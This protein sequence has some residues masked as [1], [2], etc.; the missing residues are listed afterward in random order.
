MTSQSVPNDV[1]QRRAESTDAAWIS[2][3]T[4]LAAPALSALCRDLETLYRLNPCLVFRSWETTGKDVYHTEFH[5]LSNEQNVAV[6]FT[7]IPGPADGITVT[8]GQGIKKR[9][10]FAIEPYNTGSRLVITDDY[11]KLPPSE[12][13]TRLKE[14]DKSLNAW[15]KSL[16]NYF[17]RYH[18]WSW[19]A[20]WRWYMRRLWIPMTPSARR[21][22]WIITVITLA[23]FVFFLLVLM[24]FL[25]EWGR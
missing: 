24:I 3:A 16:Y 8:Y 11:E 6:D 22:T 10:L 15:G 12:R 23:E 9:T 18:H 4:P 13:A 17:R 20:P 19:L 25:I 1:E 2:V 21:I 14:V 5:N 7:V